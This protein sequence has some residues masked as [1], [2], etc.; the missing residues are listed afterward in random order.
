MRVF[1]VYISDGRVSHGYQALEQFVIAP[2][3]VMQ[4]AGRPLDK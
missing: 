3:P 1:G 2:V 4:S